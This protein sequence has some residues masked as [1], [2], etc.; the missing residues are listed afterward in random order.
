MNAEGVR[1]YIG[2]ATPSVPDPRDRPTL[3]AK[4]LPVIA[5]FAFPNALDE[6]TGMTKVVT[7]SDLDWT[8]ARITNPTDQPSKGTLRIGYLGRD[9]VG[10]AMS[11]TT[12]PRSSPRN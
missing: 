7:D 6:I 4:V 9:K 8:I 3:K 12:S 5:R 1:R 10:S 2:L 11:R